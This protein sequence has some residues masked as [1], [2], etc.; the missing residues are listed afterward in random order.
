MSIFLCRNGHEFRS[1]IAADNSAR[2]RNKGRSPTVRLDAI[3]RRLYR[4]AQIVE[5][6][7]SFLYDEKEHGGNMHP[8]RALYIA[9]NGRK[10]RVFDGAVRRLFDCCGVDFRDHDQ[11][12]NVSDLVAA[13]FWEGDSRG[14]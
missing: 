7:Q 3:G 4:A 5:S 8:I 6:Q 9:S 11:V 14:A 10:D 12:E 13:A 1:Q 2:C